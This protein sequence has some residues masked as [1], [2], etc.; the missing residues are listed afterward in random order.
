MAHHPH[1][2]R[3]YRRTLLTASVPERL[4]AVLFVLALLWL[5]VGWALE[6][7]A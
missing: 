4:L 5:L 6:G 2:Q 7:T 1:H 3:T